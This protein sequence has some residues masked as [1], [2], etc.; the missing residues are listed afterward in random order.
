[1][2]ETS[3]LAERIHAEFDA[4]EQRLRAAELSRRREA[5]ER[6]RVVARFNEVCEKLRALWEAKLAVF[7][8]HFGGRLRVTPTITPRQRQVQL[9]FLTELAD[10]TMS[11]T[12]SV[13]T[14]LR[15]VVIDYNLLILPVFF[16]YERSARL[17]VPLDELDPDGI[18]RWVDD[19]LVS[20]VKAY[21]SVQDSALYADRLAVEDPVTGRR[22]LRANAAARLEHNGAVVYFATEESLREYRARHG[23]RE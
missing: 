7:G 21:L 15:K 8:E 5:E 19:R 23:I 12:A 13:A 2:S 6:E 11:L 1:M 4:R 14:D 17:E 18:G 16:E 10:M 3:T 20:C 9:A 22:F